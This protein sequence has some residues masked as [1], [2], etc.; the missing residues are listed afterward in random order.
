MCRGTHER[1]EEVLNNYVRGNEDSDFEV[2]VLDISA[3]GQE[4]DSDSEAEEE[5]E[6]N[7]IHDNCDF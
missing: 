1:I 4:Y 2:E 5:T 7:S 6:Q 3:G